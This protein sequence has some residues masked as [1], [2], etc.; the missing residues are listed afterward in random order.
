MNDQLIL[1]LIKTTRNRAYEC[2]KFQSKSNF[3]KQNARTLNAVVHSNRSVRSVFASLL[4]AFEST[5]KG[6]Q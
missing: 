2:Q 3:N 5:N 6:D 1:K 4:V